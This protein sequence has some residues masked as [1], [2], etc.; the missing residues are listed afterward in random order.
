MSDPAFDIVRQLRGL[1]NRIGRTETIERP[2]VSGTWTPAFVGTGTAGTFTYVANGQAGVWSRFGDQCMIHAYVQ[3]SAITVA[4]TGNIQ[5]SG[6]PFTAANV[7]MDFSLS[8][9][10]ISN[11]NYTNTAFQLCALALLNT[12]R[13]GLFESFDNAAAAAYPAANF[14]NANAALEL[15]GVYQIA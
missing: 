5:I 9:G 7:G 13:I 2:G 15:S 1:E 3:I 12:A 10:F 14:T 8:L 6:L 4:P 11:I